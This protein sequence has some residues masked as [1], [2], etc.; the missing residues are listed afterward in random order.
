MPWAM[1]ST[2]GGPEARKRHSVLPYFLL[3][4]SAILGTVL[5]KY[6]GQFPFPSPHKTTED[7]RNNRKPPSLEPRGQP[8]ETHFYPLYHSDY[9]RH[10]AT[11]PSPCPTRSRMPS[12][13]RD[14]IFL[15]SASLWHTQKSHW[16]MSA[17]G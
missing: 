9:F 5:N 13:P 7:T 1:T 10:D 16:R 11:L 8:D 6:T 4:G 14:T 17:D 15:P 12:N 2:L 3:L